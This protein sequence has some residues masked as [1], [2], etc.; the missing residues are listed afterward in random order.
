MSTTPSGAGAARAWGWVD[1]LR[2]GGTTPWQDWVGTGVQRP[3]PFPG[4]QQLEL[5]RRLNGA[6]GTRPRPVLADRVLAA[7]AAGRGR[8]DLPLVG[9]VTNG[10]GA[11]P[12]N[13]ADLPDRELVR[14]ASSLLAQDLVSR[15]ADPAP[16][17]WT[18]PWRRRVRV[19]GDPL[20]VATT[21]DALAA[22][23]RPQGGVLPHVVVAAGPLDV[24]LAHTWTRRCFEHGSRPWRD[25]VGFWQGR[26]ELP[27]RVDL[28]AAVRRRHG[29]RPLVRIVT[30]PSRLASAVGVRK[31]P[32]ERVP[33]A[34]QAELARRV[35]SVVGLLAPSEQR[36]ELMRTFQARV[37]ATTTP[38][39]AVPRS[40]RAWLE[41]AAERLIRDLRRADYPV[42]GDLADLMPRFA[43][44]TP[45]GPVGAELDR[46]VL[47][48]AL[49]MLVTDQGD[50]QMREGRGS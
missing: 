48:L 19:V 49:R 18:R 17:T 9:A 3:G 24:L 7:P 11:L 32:V 33:G 38:T 21:T 15:G 14:V 44:V 2:G 23:G 22:R 4:A 8:T 37:P 50:G 30:D 12:V 16:A 46:A 31:L 40:A 42:L 5:L 26:R 1:H 28:A 34:D 35:A 25:W 47:D 43:D 13:P 45:A 36:P 10:F 27:P 29:R 6:S 41:D 20:V 39:V